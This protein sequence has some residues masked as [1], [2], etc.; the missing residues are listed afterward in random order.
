MI[1]LGI[2][3]FFHDLNAGAVNLATGAICAA[4]EERFSR[5][6][7]HAVWGRERSSIDCVHHVLRAVGA[8]PEQVTHLVLA[9]LADYPIKSWLRSLFPQARQHQVEHHLCHAAAAFHGS[10][11]DKAAIL[12][13][14]GFGD[15]HSG[16]L[17]VGEGRRITPLRYIDFK[18][19]IGLLYL[20][21]THTIGLGAFGSEG[22]TQG[23]APYGTPRL[24]AGLLERIELRGDGRFRLA[25]ELQAHEAYLEEDLH[26]NV[27]ILSNPF[28][29]EHVA[30]RTKDEP[31]LAGHMDAAASAQAVLDQV[32]GHA[33]ACLLRETGLDRLVLTGGV[34]QNSSTNGALQQGAGFAEIYAHPASAD[35]GNGLGAALHIAF[36]ELGA[37]FSA[38]MDHVYHGQS[39]A[40]DEVVAAGR[41]CGRDLSLLADPAAVAAQLL[42]AGRFVGW[43]QGRSEIGARALGNRSIL[44]DPRGAATRDLLNERVKHREWFRPFAP[45]VL[46]EAAGDWFVTGHEQPAMMF[47]VPVRPERREEVPGITHVDGTARVQ[48]VRRETNQLYHDLISRFAAITGVP[49][50]LNTS[51]NDA[52]EPIV[53]TPEDAFACFDSTG[54]DALIIGEHALFKAGVG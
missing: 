11:Y 9:D 8:A 42:A 18:D 44:A 16:L 23:L 51:F 15:G 28:V 13:L 5:R 6:K 29:R 21:V 35:R 34:A 38:R 52:G 2:G 50:V 54:L 49:L 24:T 31:L 43:F 37:E 36:E 33:A 12:S 19:S 7:H 39:F 46:A 32:A 26:T 47:T 10:G 4:E 17:A 22:K 20:Q 25:R 14:D 3:G 1:V 45:S 40:P 53:E 41:R 27:E 30:R 48:T